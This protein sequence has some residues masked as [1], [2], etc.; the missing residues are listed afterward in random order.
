MNSAASSV[1]R[2]AEVAL[3]RHAGFLAVMLC[4]G[5][6]F[7]AA[8]LLPHVLQRF[9]REHPFQGIEI[10]PG[11]EDFYAARIREVADGFWPVA[12]VYFSAPKD[13][14]YLQPAL[15]EWTLATLGRFLGFTPVEMFVFSKG[16][17]AVILVVV[18]TGFFASVT[19]RGWESLLATAVLLFAGSTLNAPWDIFKF[20]TDT[21]FNYDFLRFA[22]PI[23]PQ[24][25]TTWFLLGL[26]CLSSWLR[27]R[28]SWKAL[29]A[30]V[31]AGVMLYSYVF[32]W[33]YFGVVVA[34]L[35]V[36]FAARREWRRCLDLLLLGAIFAV[37]A[38]P[39]LVNLIAL[40]H[41]P[42]YEETIAR[43][44]LV[45]LRAAV[46]GVW[47]LVFCGV[48]GISRRLWPNTWP[49][50][51]AVALGGLIAINQQ[52][53]TG[54]YLQPHH[55]HWYFIQPLAGMT[56]LLFLFTSLRSFLHL[57]IRTLL[58]GTVLV[59]VILFSVV[60]QS[61]AYAV[62]RP[63]WGRFQEFAPLFTALEKFPAGTVAYAPDYTIMNLL[64]IYTSM[65]VY[66]AGNALSFLTSYERARNVLFFELWFE[67]LSPG[68]AE[69]RFYED[70][71]PHVSS[72]LFMIYYR[73]TLGDYSRIP[74]DVIRKHVEEYRMYHALPLEE[75]LGRYPLHLLIFTPKSKEQD[76][77]RLFRERG[78]VIWED[79]GYTIVSLLP[80]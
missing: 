28:R 13:Q 79:N 37:L 31:S 43:L 41:H 52:V 11:D 34:L 58:F 69:K 26:W 8:V 74:D 61:R 17:F 6:F 3:L 32:A 29:L 55:Y 36:W 19:G 22:R 50:L 75:K 7:A 35:L 62:Y 20:L 24:W 25:S 53:V 49:L 21:S 2:R 18:F 56:A 39:Y 46:L 66:T 60:Q 16:I 59:A 54:M 48:A 77:Y 65:D 51:P 38:I 45:P 14:P 80:S 10:M 76:A 5:L 33:T 47:L 68:E 64:P 70:L 72:R 30:G 23:N 27:E 67:G 73:E 71:R 15:P 78:N 4:V 44:G 1:L 40:K 9:E 42:W 63:H 12:N 57:V